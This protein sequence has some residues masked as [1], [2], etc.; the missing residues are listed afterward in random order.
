MKYCIF[1][2]TF[3]PPHTGHGY[4]AQCACDS[5]HFDKLFWVPSSVPPLKNIPQTPFQHRLEMVKRV[6]AGN[7]QFEVSDIED[8]LSQPSYSLNTIRALKQELGPN[9]DW[10]FLIGADNW[11]LFPTWH[12][13]ESILKEV[14]LVVFPRKDHPIGP[15][16]EKT[17]KLPMPEMQIE[18]RML[19]EVLANSK[20]V[21]AAGIP[22][23][24]REYILIN[25]LYGID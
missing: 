18:S 16:P 19:R 22:E 20:D 1:G 5:L 4:L 3:D 13:P 21:N 23:E 7:R 25:H 8:R 10:H 2:G 14:T 12:Q 24:I 17:L 11:T 15:L 9:H 6:I